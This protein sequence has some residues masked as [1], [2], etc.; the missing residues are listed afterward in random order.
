MP[1]RV[2]VTAETHKPKNSANSTEQT[3]WTSEDKTVDD[4]QQQCPDLLVNDLW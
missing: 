2:H 1:T 3:T 4:S